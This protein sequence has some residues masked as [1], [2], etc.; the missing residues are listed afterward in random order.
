MVASAFGLDYEWHDGAAPAM[1]PSFHS[2]DEAMEYTPAPVAT[3]RVGKHVLAM[4]EFFLNETRGRLPLSLTDVQSPLNTA[5]NLVETSSLLVEM[6][7]RPAGVRVF[8]SR[9]AD[10]LVDFTHEQIARMRDTLVAP[11]HGFASSRHFRGMGM[12]DDNMLMLSPVMY[13]DCAAESFV[14]AGRP[15]GGAVF[16]SCGDWSERV[17]TVRQLDDLRMVDGAFSAATDP[18][19][20]SPE[21]FA[22]SFTGTGVVVNARIVG[23]PDTIEY[24]VRR[25]W[26]PGMK[27]LV[28][29]YCTTPEEQHDA[30]GRIQAVCTP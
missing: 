9:L 2:I 25:L 27:L 6:L 16:H 19:P 1:R 5:L 12:S 21:R 23:N 13:L 11:G 28:V 4:V 7:S 26:R 30:Y 10:L 17:D 3:T 29:T 15:F 20:N 22:E 18:A 14:R 8:L 24:V